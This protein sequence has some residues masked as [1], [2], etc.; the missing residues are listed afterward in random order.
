MSSSPDP[1]SQGKT[2]A[3]S[4]ENGAIRA[5][6][7]FSWTRC[8]GR[9]PSCLLKLRI[10]ESLV[11]RAAFEGIPS[12]SRMSGS[13]PSTLLYPCQ[14]IGSSCGSI[15]DSCPKATHDLTL[16]WNEEGKPNTP[17]C[18]SGRTTASSSSDRMT[19]LRSPR[20]T[21][22]STLS[23]RCC[24]RVPRSIKSEEIRWQIHIWMKTSKSSRRKG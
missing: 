7:T 24:I 19:N 9:C 10:L 3:L 18:C 16:F 8:F 14:Q 11:R 23:R 15:R 13:V 21:C 2:R 1:S 4:S 6:P 22:S 12:T 17:R 20:P 5:W